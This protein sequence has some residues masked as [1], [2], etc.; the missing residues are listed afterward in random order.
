MDPFPVPVPISGPAN[1]RSAQS[2][3]METHDTL[4]DTVLSLFNE[5]ELPVKRDAIISA[6]EDSGS[7]STTA[8]GP[9]PDNAQWVSTHL[10]P[11]TLL[12]REELALYNKLSQTG[13][14]HPILREPDL[15]ATRPFLETDIRAAIQSLENSTATIQ[16]QSDTLSRQCDILRKQFRQQESLDGDRG[17]DITR[18]RKK[19]E[20]GRQNTT[21]AAN[22]LS[23]DLEASFRSA[24]ESAGV[25]NKRILSTL[26]TQLKQDDK[27]LNYLENLMSSIKFNS[28][29]ADT[30]KRTGQLSS[31][32]ADY[33]AEEIH[34][35]LDR[36]YL[37]EIEAGESA[38]SAVSQDQAS[39]S[40]ESETVAALEEELGSLFPEIEVLAEMST[41]QEFQEPILREIQ[42]GH[43]QLRVV[44]HQKLEKV[45]DSMVDMTLSKQDLIKQLGERGSANEVLEQ[46][47]N[48]YQAE[49]AIP[50]VPQPSS[51][52]ESLRRR[53][54]QPGM[55]LSAARNPGSGPGSSIPD[56]PQPDLESL[57]RR[58]G[59][60]PE[61]VLRPR[62]NGDVEGGGA[63]GM[64]EKR[65][66]MAETL[67]S[68]G[69]AVNS[70]L[71][72]QLAFSDHA[73]RLLDSSLHANSRFETSLSDPGQLEAL[74]ALEGDLAELQKGVRGVDLEILHQRD[75]SR[76]RLLERWG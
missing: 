55:I 60:S 56:Q 39:I 8:T 58:V 53:S 34:D 26:S 10:H 15:D 75:K 22:E 33:V 68:L 63:Q 23:D 28:N 13:N 12:S 64:H 70:P 50:L 25:E 18:L 72:G 11:D 16:K 43:S 31:V 48:L 45:L 14:L 5:R 46:L 4:A 59:L 44:S 62:A 47:A 42:N 69:T 51:R 24:T 38:A 65:I 6:L 30:V 19:H 74:G 32:L 1:R 67:R 36:L 29:D 3:K 17:R 61:S 54:L 21:I 52:R 2:P 40:S 27:S 57:L 41:R 7:A 76:A 37:E 71:V 35:R 9:G 49:T 66:Q 20:V 73:M